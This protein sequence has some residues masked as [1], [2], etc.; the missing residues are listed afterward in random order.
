MKIQSAISLFIRLKM[1]YF[2]KIGVTIIEIDFFVTENQHHSAFK[3]FSRYTSI[4]K[5]S[6]YVPPNSLQFFGL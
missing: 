4:L 6:G 5:L 1:K 2:G 3:G